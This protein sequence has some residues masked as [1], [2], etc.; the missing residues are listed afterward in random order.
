MILR[1]HR[2]DICIFRAPAN[3]AIDPSAGR[4]T[5]PGH[6]GKARRWLH[7]GALLAVIS[8]TRLACAWRVRWRSGILLLGL[9]LSAVGVVLPSG[10]VLFLG[11][12]AVLF[13]LLPGSAATDR[14]LAALQ[15][16]RRWHGYR[17]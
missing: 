14:R 4:V 8:I 1:S 9:L 13:A 3:R 2:R 10:A 15:A 11:A 7:T 12:A 6:G 5:R 17:D 16:E